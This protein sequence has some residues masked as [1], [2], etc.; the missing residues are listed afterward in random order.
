MEQSEL[1]TMILEKLDSLTRENEKLR[2]VNNGLEC[3][4][5]KYSA[6]IETLRTALKQFN[7]EPQAQPTNAQDTPL[8]DLFKNGVFN[9]AFWEKFR[10]TTQC[11][12]LHN[13]IRD[14]AE[15]QNRACS[16]YELLAKQFPDIFDTYGP[17]LGFV[18]TKG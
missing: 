4:V 12:N 7:K 8:T 5:K 15:N 6:E 17:I 18:I 2:Q 1:Y 11:K 10:E 13:G 14:I 16:E 3:T 9:K